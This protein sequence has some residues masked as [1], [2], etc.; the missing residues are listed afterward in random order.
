MSAYADYSK[1]RYG[2]ETIEREWGFV[3]YS[4]VPPYIALQDVYVKPEF[5]RGIKGLSFLVDV[6][7]IGKEAG[8]THIWTQVWLSDSQAAR[9]VRCNLACNFKMISADG[10]RIVFE[11]EIGG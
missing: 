5:R 2:H 9:A 6:Q 8:M 11:K 4:F 10:G 1:E 7:R 3:S